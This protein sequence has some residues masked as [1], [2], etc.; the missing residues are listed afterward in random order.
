MAEVTARLRRIQAA[1]PGRAIYERVAVGP[2]TP[3]KL[4]PPARRLLL[5]DDGVDYAE[6]LCGLLADEGYRC[7]ALHDSAGVLDAVAEFRP[8]L[9]LLDVGLPGKSGFRLCWEIKSRP[10]S[11]SLPVVLVSAQVA[12]ADHR[13]GLAAQADAYLDKPV[14]VPELL[15]VIRLLLDRAQD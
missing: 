1:L 15:A 2:R 12:D 6:A 4:E 9:V 7:R 14:E 8:D 10:Q 13:L 11:Q 3:I 5:V